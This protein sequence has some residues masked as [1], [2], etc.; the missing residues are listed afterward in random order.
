MDST[1]VCGQLAEQC[2]I[3]NIGS[4]NLNSCFYDEIFSHCG[5]NELN[6]AVFAIIAVVMVF[7]LYRII[8]RSF[9]IDRNFFSLVIA[10]VIFGTSMRV[11]TDSLE[12]SAVLSIIKSF[13]GLTNGFYNYNIHTVSPGI[14][15]TVTIVLLVLLLIT[16]R[17]GYRI[18]LPVSYAL[19]AIHLIPL[20]LSIKFIIFLP[21]VILLAGIPTLLAYAILSR[22]FDQKE[23]T[24]KTGLPWFLLLLPIF[25]HALDG[26][27]TFLA[28]DVS[29]HMGLSYGEQHVLAGAIGSSFGY[30]TF[31]LVKIL[32]SFAAVAY[33]LNSF[34]GSKAREENPN[35]DEFSFFILVFSIPGLAPGLRDILRLMIGV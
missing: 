14:Y 35:L 20:L 27:A 25:A 11:I 6:T 5:Y 16:S 18:S 24:K 34:F 10:L 12:S 1:G 8:S 22:F 7:A 29:Q 13:D 32:I 30:F 31:Y 15:F 23:I 3:A 17:L 28:I 19:A 33:L 26:G 2:R 21:M 9:R 4:A